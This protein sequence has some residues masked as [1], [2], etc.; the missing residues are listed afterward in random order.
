[1]PILLLFLCLLCINQ[2]SAQNYIPRP[3]CGTHEHLLK[4]QKH[5]HFG[6]SISVRPALSQKF[7]SPSGRFLIHYDISGPNS[8]P[9][10][11]ADGNSVPD[12]VDSTAAYFDY[13]YQVE[14]AEIGYRPPPVDTVDGATYDVYLEDNLGGNYTYGVT[15]SEF[16]ND[17]ASPVTSTSYISIDN[18]FS[19]RDTVQFGKQKQ[20]A[21]YDTSYNALKITIAH[22]FHHAIQFGYAFTQVNS[23]IYEM[24][25]TWMEYRVFPD[26]RVY[27]EYLPLLFKNT[28]QYI[29]SD[30]RA[31]TGYAYAVFGQ[32]IY[33]DY[34]DS[35]LKRTWELIGAD[36][37]S[38]TPY[39]YNFLD[40][41]FKE[42][43]S[44]L[45]EKWC[46]FLPWLYFT[47]SRAEENRFF[48]NA[49]VYPEVRFLY[50]SVFT[51]P[52]TS[53]SGF[54]L[55]YEFRFLRVI[56]PESSQDA[57]VTADIALANIDTKALVSQSGE[58][59][60]YAITIKK[61]PET[62]FKNIAGTPYFIK[63]EHNDNI[64]DTI[65]V[66]GS[67]QTAAQ[68]YPNPF[69]KRIDQE[70]FFPVPSES[71]LIGK[72][73]LTLFKSDMAP[74]YS[75]LLP[76][77]IINGQFAIRW[78]DVPE[79]LSSGVYIFSVESDENHSLGKII[80]QN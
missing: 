26:L 57:P 16:I 66:S 49:A 51:Q 25:S 53:L 7:L 56:L 46:G 32:Y 23:L 6:Q 40:S 37:S 24:T 21:F 77:E 1:M 61:S 18:D 63:V 30:M 22:E 80:I 35:L 27:E 50:D 44:A 38:N 10:L 54:L 28:T 69:K 41:A 14:V 52:S 4:N 2:A 36:K 76:V 71:I 17:N 34:G 43:G 72:A 20:R 3:H 33:A 45:S 60:N 65:F 62:G 19:S 42:R 13:A 47:G 74:V 8:V 64:C 78:A 9:L 79:N 67:I 55:P 12:Y 48:K 59:Q 39:L 29:F 75:A 5:I 31:A 73:R 68:A 58:T 15:Y 70:A 11:D